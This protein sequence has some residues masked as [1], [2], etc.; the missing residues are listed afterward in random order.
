MASVQS[1]GLGSD[2]LTQDQIDKLKAADSKA[3]L[4]PIQKKYHR[5][6]KKRVQS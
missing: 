3:L 5:E 1:L 4:D 6:Q 2:V